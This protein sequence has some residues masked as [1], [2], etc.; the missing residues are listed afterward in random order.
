MLTTWICYF[1][2]L[3]D[4][5]VT[6]LYLQSFDFPFLLFSV[7]KRIDLVLS[8]PKQ[9]LNL[10]S[11][12]ESHILETFLVSFFLFAPD[13][14]VEIINVYH[15]HREI[16]CSLWHIKIH[17]TYNKGPRMDLCG[18]PHHRSVEVKNLSWTLTWNFLMDRYYLH[19]SI[20]LH[21]KPNNGNFRSSILWS[22]VPNAFWRYIKIIPVRRPESKSSDIL[23]AK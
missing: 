20:T 7:E 8:S 2:V 21:K 3:L 9:M 4:F 23:S 1:W 17:N 5:D 19:Q 15:L 22:I 16:D 11:T 18:T 13:L 14:Y 10:L 6:I 12:N